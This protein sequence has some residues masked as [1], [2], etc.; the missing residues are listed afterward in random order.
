MASIIHGS[1]GTWYTNVGKSSV[2][3]VVLLS[4]GFV[5]LDG[6]AGTP[7][8]PGAYS[9]QLRGHGGELLL[10]VGIAVTNI[11]KIRKHRIDDAFL[12]SR[13]CLFEHRIQLPLGCGV[14][15]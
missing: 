4:T 14:H 7:C 6:I 12:F 10:A 11:T 8:L 2:G 1:G 3:S 15:D 5:S 9:D 13:M